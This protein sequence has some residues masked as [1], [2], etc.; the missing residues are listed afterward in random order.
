MARTA[1]FTVS[2]SEPSQLRAKISYV[3]VDVT[4]LAP[5]DY[6]RMT[7]TLE[8]DVGQTIKQIVVPIR[9]EVANRPSQKFVTTLFNPVNCTI[10]DPDG[11]AVIPAGPVVV[12][13]GPLI[14]SGLIT[15]AYHNVSGRGGYFHY[16]SGTSEGQSIGIEGSFLAYDTLRS[17][18]VD[19]RSAANW[20]KDNALSMLDAMGTGS[21]TGPMLRQPVPTDPNTI[22]LMHWLFAVRGEIPEQA[23]VYGFPATK[24]GAGKLII[25]ANA[26]GADVFRVW[27]IYPASSYLL[28]QSPYSPTYDSITPTVDTSVQVL[29]SMISYIGDTVVITPPENEITGWMIVY[30]Y[31][32]GGIIAQGEAQEAYP[33]WT[34]IEPG[35]SACAPDT[36]RWFDYAMSLAISLDDRVGK[37][38]RWNNLRAAM[39]LT[40]VRGQDISDL[41]EIM[42]PLPHFD[43]IPIKGDPSGT[44]CFSSHPSALPPSAELIAQ[45]ANPDWMGYNFWARVGGSGGSASPGEF[46][47][48]PDNMMDAPVAGKDFF[49]GAVIATVPATSTVKQVQYGRGISYTWRLANAYQQADQYLFVALAC[50]RKPVAADGEHCYVFVSTTKYYSEDTRWYADVGQYAAFIAAATPDKPFY[51]LIPRSDFKA[52]DGDD[53]VLPAGVPFENFGISMEMKAAYTLRI[54]AMRLLSG[55]SQEA[56]TADVQAAVRGSQM[57]FFP[58]SMPFAINADTKKQQFVGWNGSPFHGYQLPDLWWFLNSEASA[59]HA[60]INPATTMPVPELATGALQYPITANTAGGAAKPVHA[61][62][63][64]QQIMFLKRAQEKWVESGGQVGPFAHTF[65]LNTAARMTLGNP[66]PHTWV[67]TNDDPN[68]RLAGYQ[69]R[70]VDSLSRLAYL[71]KDTAS[72][73]DATTLAISLAVSWL[74]RLISDWPNLDGKNYV[75]PDMGLVTIYG[76]PTDYDDPAKGNPKTLYEEPHTAALVLRACMWLKLSGKLTTTQLNAING[77]SKQC[78]DYL[79][80]RYRTAPIDSMRYTWANIEATT[81]ESYFGFWEFEIIATIGYLL[82]YPAGAPDGVNSALLRQRLVETCSWLQK[83]VR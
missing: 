65:V 37:A 76:P 29:P 45:G 32:N 11:D 26:H 60:G 17:G 33:C 35:Y 80:L 40:A 10:A 8:F 19:E 47:W 59:I 64:E 7:G 43:A 6:T 56:V 31:E 18:T 79:E 51:L 74:G 58:G 21:D 3:T 53:S 73:A 41:R 57:P 70:V 75:D 4:A 27:Q 81:T 23:I 77:L 68:T 52:K 13:N 50:T 24:N 9:D 5:D 12:V 28:Y 82:K 44:F 69:V 61:L 72:W 42:K 34:K 15:N 83:N 71:A 63:A 62:L 36:F 22:T 46:C 2:L 66:T 39:R 48:T 1:T 30:G 78:W 16:N 67:Y 20:Y 49:N 54:V 38:T 25:P 55:A 14:Q